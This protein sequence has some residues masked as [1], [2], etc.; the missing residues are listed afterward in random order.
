MKASL[1]RR[2]FRTI[3]AIGLINV[4]VTLIAVEFIYEDMEE[5]ILQQELSAEREVL[6][7]Q[8]T[9]PAVQAWRTAWLT[10]IYIPDGAV[11]ADMPAMFV[12][13]EAPFSAEVDIGEKSYLISIERTMQPP[14]VLYL[15]Q[16]VTLLENREDVL[17]LGM[18]VLG[19][20]M[21]LIG[22]LLSRIGTQRIVRPLHDLA[23][24]IAGIRPGTPFARI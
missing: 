23:E 19:L 6:E 22:A 10:A 20:G 12:D 18:T 16:D 5:T 1:A 8:I 9:G 2:L 4:I 17:Q 7:R 14:G 21:L 13:R 15:A 3:F 11:V 24:H